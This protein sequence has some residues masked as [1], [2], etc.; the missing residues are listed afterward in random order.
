MSCVMNLPSFY[1]SVIYGVQKRDGL[2]HY[3]W[4]KNNIQVPHKKE[5][6]KL[7]HKVRLERTLLKWMKDYLQAKEMKTLIRDKNS[8][9]C[10]VTS[11]GHARVCIRTD[12]VLSAYKLQI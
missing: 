3:I 11:G 4:E 2:M 5:K 7:V 10:K 6:W 9:W 12:C 8:D 1:K